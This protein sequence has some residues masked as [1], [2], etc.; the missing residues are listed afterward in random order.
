MVGYTNEDNTNFLNEIIFRLGGW[1]VIER[2]KWD[3]T[4]FNWIIFIEEARDIGYFDKSFFNF[5]VDLDIDE[6]I[7]SPSVSEINLLYVN[8]VGTK[9][10]LCC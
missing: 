5:S 9:A 10:S 7:F 4:D 1:P 8:Y 6:R 3:K 2:N